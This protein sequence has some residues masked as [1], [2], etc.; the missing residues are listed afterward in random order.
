MF[1]QQ[2]GAWFLSLLVVFGVGVN[3]GREYEPEEANPELKQKV[4]E[5][6]DAIV[7][8]MAGLADDLNAE[9]EK[10]M[11][12]FRQSEFVHSVEDFFNNVK[13]IAELLGEE[14]FDMNW[15][16]YDLGGGWGSRLTKYKKKRAALGIITP[17]ISNEIS[18]NTV[19]KK[20]KN[21]DF[22]DIAGFYVG[23][24]AFFGEKIYKKLDFVEKIPKNSINKV[25]SALKCPNKYKKEIYEICH[26][27]YDFLDFISAASKLDKTLFDEKSAIS[28]YKLQG[29]R[30][31][32]QLLCQMFYN[33]K[34]I[35]KISACLI[36]DVP[37][38]L[39]IQVSDFL[40]GCYFPVA[41]S[42]VPTK[43]KWVENQNG[44]FLYG[45]YQNEWLCVDVVGVGRFNLSNYELANRLNYIGGGGKTVPYLICYNWIDILTAYHHFGSNLFIRD[46]KNDIFNH[47]WFVFGPESKINVT[48][49]D[50]YINGKGE[51]QISPTL[52]KSLITNKDT[53]LTVNLQGDFVNYCDKNDI[54]YSK[55]EIYDW[56]ELYSQYM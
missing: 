10:Q 51:Y 14:V 44:W 32:Y 22:T 23:I 27:K 8:E 16:S 42:P 17:G 46:L 18:I 5:H 55:S 39:R 28:V 49:K 21:Q 24:L 29:D 36:N 43:F 54:F 45:L 25:V 37:I 48:F 1:F 47:Y 9:A 52:N 30:A 40:S 3:A 4:T 15:F 31:I 50:G 26:T 20:L 33:N 12:E 2:L 56:F 6:L 11:E 38:D 7:D 19:Y 34:R 13:E 35:D 41:V 53:Y